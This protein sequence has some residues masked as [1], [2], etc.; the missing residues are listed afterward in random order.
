M[1]TSRY[2][3]IR[4]Q[5]PT[6]I[7]RQADVVALAPS[8]HHVVLGTAGSGKTTMAMLRA[9][10]LADPRAEHHGRT[11]L[12][13]Y[14]RA[15]LAFLRQV[16]TGDDDLLE[17]RNYHH[18]ALGYL[19]SRGL[20]T[21]RAVAQRDER[22]ELIS[23]ALR[24]TREEG[25]N[26]VLD[27]G[28]SFFASEFAW[29]GRNGIASE[30][31]YLAAD[32]VGRIHPLTRDQR[33]AVY[34]ARLAYE[35]A[36]E[37]AGLSYDWDDLASAVVDQ[38]E[39][40][41]EPRRYRHIVIDEG[42]D[43]SVQMLRSLVSAVDPEGSFTL[44]GDAAQQIYGRGVSW[45]SAGIEVS[46][47]W[48]FAHNYRNSAPIVRLAQA[49]A[50]MPYYRDV[51]D[52]V[53]PDE[54]VDEG[55]PP[56]LRVFENPSDE[57]DWVIAQAQALGR[58][59]TVGVLFRR[60]VDAGR[61]VQACRGAERLDRDTPLWNAQPGIWSATVNAAKGFEFQSVILPELST[62]WWPEPQ[63]VSAEGEEEA[64]VADGRLLYV[65]VTRARQNL[66]MTATGTITE[67]LPDEDGL[68]VQSKG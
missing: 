15:L 45:R 48:E 12:V 58:T 56:T 16:I 37:E 57:R 65:A 19:K 13:T 43:F 38:F 67:L 26:A 8:G 46:K 33:T 9:M 5:L 20:P 36:R 64:T 40:D 11:L 7:G 21:D 49:I 30:D 24:T 17:V 68:W 29:M 28:T 10:V 41:D 60:G 44:F 1:S 55:P 31:D 47:V 6:P 42:Q 39:A 61:F 27:R 51:E 32:R 35:Q 62:D 54:D 50:A 25:S 14:N 53:E 23:T 22:R 4:D 18:F 66:L 59:G 3:A 63:A 34:A 52:L 2:D